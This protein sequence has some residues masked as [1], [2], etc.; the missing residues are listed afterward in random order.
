MKQQLLLRSQVY[1]V[2][3]VLHIYFKVVLTAYEVQSNIN[4]A[5]AL[6]LET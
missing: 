1:T 5:D 4:V 2:M 3:L 6:Y